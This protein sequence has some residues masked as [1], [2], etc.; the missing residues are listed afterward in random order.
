MK[1]TNLTKILCA[2]FFIFTF[3][4]AVN[5]EFYSQGEISYTQRSYKDDNNSASKDESG[6][7]KARVDLAIEKHNF[8]AVF[9]GLVRNDVEDD[10]R[11]E[12]IV[13]EAYI[14]YDI[15]GWEFSY[16]A[17]LFNWT[18]T[19]AFHPADIINSR[20][21][22]SDLENFDKIGEWTVGLE[23]KIG[24]I[25]FYGFYLPRYHKPI[26]PT[27]KN[28][29]GIGVEVKGP[30]WHEPNGEVSD[31]KFG[32]QYGLQV[33]TTIAQADISLHYV[34]HMDRSQP[35][36]DSSY[37]PHY[38]YVD[39]IGGTY[40]Q[41]IDL[42]LLKL[43]FSHRKFVDPTTIT[44]TRGDRKLQDHS[45][46]A[47]G[48][49]FSITHL[50]GQETTFYLEGQG[51]FGLEKSERSEISA[52]QRDIFIGMR[53]AFNDVYGKEIFISGIYDL[54]RD[55]EYLA[56]ISYMQRLSDRWKVTLGARYID[57]PVK[58]QI[59]TII[60]NFDDPQGLEVYDNDHQIYSRLSY[61]F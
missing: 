52:F 60:G 53:H 39:Q 49:E 48:T 57:A 35:L 16:G 7:I 46:V 25:N 6:E 59:S 54:E 9:K 21:L 22:D 18:A 55:H 10:Q 37:V 29:L 5:A 23:K 12:S 24:K 27:A 1:K 61:Y 40:Q 42:L 44:T 43:E 8:K 32:N 3:S 47:V 36:L 26:F 4:P 45:I 20:V 17:K 28:R 2:S 58:Q 41:A 11:D 13:E 51:V 38:F 33:K 50:S 30:I 31:D 15:E 56:T 34:H 19:E 14:L